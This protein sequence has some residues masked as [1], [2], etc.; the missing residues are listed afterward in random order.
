MLFQR[1]PM[2]DLFSL[3]RSLLGISSVYPEE[4]ACSE[5]LADRLCAL[6]YTVEKQVVSTSPIRQNIFA[7][8]GQN[9]NPTLI[10]NSHMDVVPPYFGFSEDEENVYGRGACDAKGS[11]AMQIVALEQLWGEGNIR[12]GDVGSVSRLFPWCKMCLRV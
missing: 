7:Y 12:D 2:T 5:F 11:I 10:L 3:H 1:S 8:L 4:H 9:R 6:G